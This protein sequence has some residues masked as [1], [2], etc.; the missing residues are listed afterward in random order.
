[1][2]TKTELQAIIRN[3][4]QRSPD[5]ASLIYALE[6]LVEQDGFEYEPPPYRRGDNCWISP[7]TGFIHHVDCETTDQ[8]GDG[9]VTNQH[10]EIQ[11]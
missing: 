5:E 7:N 3:L 11:R 4:Q 1:M 9:A 2:T 8:F 10:G 6:Q